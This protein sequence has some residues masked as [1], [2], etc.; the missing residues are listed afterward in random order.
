MMRRL[1]FSILLF[2]FITASLFWSHASGAPP[3]P[4]P[5]PLDV[6]SYILL[7]YHSGHVLA[8]AN[9]DER[10]APASLTKLMTAYVVFQELRAG[11]IK[12]TDLAPVSEKAWRTTGSRTFIE[13]GTSVAVEEL[14]K[15]M[16]IQSGNDASVALA[17]HIAGAEE[18]FADLMNR[19]GQRLGLNGTHFVNSTGLT[20]PDH[21]TTARD[22]AFL[23]RA[24]IRDFPEYY[25]W[26]SER[27]FTY[28]GITQHNRNRLLGRNP[29]VD[30]GKT[31]YTEAAGYC[32][33][34]SAQRDGMRLISVV[35][36]AKGEK[37][38]E[39]ASQALLIYG[40]RF[41]ESHKL[42]DGGTAL[43]EVRIWKG[44]ST[45]LPLGLEQDLYVT[46]LRGQRKDFQTALHIQPQ[47][48]AP[49]AKDTPYGVM[50][51]SLADTVI[52]ERPLIA[53]TEVPLG[54]WWRRLIDQIILFI[55][56][57]FPSD[58]IDD[59]PSESPW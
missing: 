19:T 15:G 33:A 30:G 11:Q 45:K 58:G 31:G 7:D 34:T 16:I 43:T 20:H 49:A 44:A 55:Y 37:A 26:Y 25:A 5:P 35:L 17:E 4:K 32:L 39:D 56:G 6:R 3:T 51:V 2:T 48:L 24:I 9:A 28:N 1:L 38:R 22:V 27:E 29:S 57:L 36:G 50:S 52:A 53:L 46:T 54:G 41:F 10:A 18:G 21:Y 59:K 23:L 47:I 8:E 42:Y 13:V 12:L 14:L 40:F